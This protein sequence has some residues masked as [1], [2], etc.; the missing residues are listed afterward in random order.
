MVVIINY[1]THVGSSIQVWG[2]SDNRLQIQGPKLVQGKEIRR[3]A[4]DDPTEL[5]TEEKH[6]GCFIIHNLGNSFKC[7][8]HWVQAGCKTTVHAVSSI[9]VQ[10]PA[11]VING[12][13]TTHTII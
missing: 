11:L 9:A 5:C 6:R 8:T 2:L 7:R 1:L 10:I 4:R 3:T 13:S 12:T